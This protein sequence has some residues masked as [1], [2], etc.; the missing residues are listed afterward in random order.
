MID[1]R[2]LQV[3][4]A[5]A[6][7]GTV[8]A[9]AEALYLTP[10]AVSQQLNALESEAGQPLLA[11]RGRR[12]RLTAAGELL[13]QH[14]KAVLAELERAEASLAACAAG[15]VGQVEVASFASAITQV[16]APSIAALRERAPGVN[17]LVRDAEAHDSLRLLLAGEVDVAISM[18]YGSTLQADGDRL[19]RYP[20]YAEPFDAVL[21]PGHPLGE[22]ADIALDDLRESDWIVP[23]P[24]NPCRAVTRT[25]CENAGFIP[26]ITHTS[27]DFHAVVAL[28]TAGTGVALVPRTAIPTEHGAQVRPL[29]DNA[30]TRR[31]FAAVQHGREEHPLLRTLLD[32]LVTQARDAFGKAW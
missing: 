26:H 28:V 32:T 27:D 3:L 30:P 22:S 5:L 9:A 31:V 19:I 10:S 20:L 18:E 17:V 13:A 21:P 25:C 12:V 1:P 7:H 6:D 23:L 24:G 8:R 14:A 15:T 4:R 2:R 16:V 11:R 29:T